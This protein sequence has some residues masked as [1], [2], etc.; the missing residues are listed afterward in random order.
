[1]TTEDTNDTGELIILSVTH[2]NS[3]KRYRMTQ[4]PQRQTETCRL[5]KGQ[6]RSLVEC[7]I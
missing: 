6:H 4:P 3:V 5:Q 7:D 2:R 1:M